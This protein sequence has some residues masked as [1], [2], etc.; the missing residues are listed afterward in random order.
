MALEEGGESFEDDIEA[1]R[2]FAGADHADVEGI[3]EFWVVAHG[4]GEAR[5]FADFRL[6]IG[7]GCFERFVFGLI[8]KGAEA[9]D[10]WDC[11][12]LQGAELARKVFDILFRDARSDFDSDGAFL[13]LG[14]F[15]ARFFVDFAEVDAA[16]A[17]DFAQSR[18]IGR[19]FRAFDGLTRRI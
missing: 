15:D 4:I 7:E 1:T 12:F 16:L 3:E 5:T 19:I 9:F 8:G 2:R 14:G 10:E 11:G 13:R 6:D 17:Q 18:L